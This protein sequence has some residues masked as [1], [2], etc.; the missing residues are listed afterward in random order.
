MTRVDDIVHALIEEIKKKKPAADSPVASTRELGRRFGVSPLTADRAVKKM[1]EQGV[2]Y[3]VRGKGTF[4]REVPEEQADKPLIGYASAP[5]YTLD[6]QIR[7]NELALAELRRRFRVRIL[8]QHELKDPVI[9]PRE[10][11][12]LDG[13]LLTS[14]LMDDEIRRTLSSF[15]KPVVSMLQEY[16]HD[17]GLHEVALDFSRAFADAIAR[18]KDIRDRKFHIIFENHRNGRYRMECFR[19]K[20]RE[21]GVPESRITLSTIQFPRPLLFS[22]AVLRKIRSAVSGKFVFCTSDVVSYA[23]LEY[24][25]K[26]GP[27]P[28]KDFELLSCDNLE[29]EDTELSTVDCHLLEVPLAAVNLL[30]AVL[31]NPD[32]YRH[33]VHIPADLVVR[34]TALA[35]S[36]DE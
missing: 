1:V 9:G 12:G 18:I 23:F 31:K 16:V 4:F 17:D 22:E 7:I 10:L 8:M 15:G 34:K 33:C 32:N 19:R 13:L 3:R 6:V 35:D 28:G 14:D 24:L 30:S 20:L 25:K 2:Y 11:A 36:P 5:R 27:V 21:A 26:N 29:P